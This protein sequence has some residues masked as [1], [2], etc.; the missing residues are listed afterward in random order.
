MLKFTRSLLNS[1]LGRKRTIENDDDTSNHDQ[2]SK[3]LKTDENQKS[4]YRVTVSNLPVY[5]IG[6]IKKLLN[7]AGL[8][9]IKKAPEWTY[10]HCFAD[11]KEEAE[12]A[13]NQ[14]QN[15]QYKG[16]ALDIKWEA[17]S[18]QEH[19]QAKVTG[20]KKNKQKAKMWEDLG[21]DLDPHERLAYQVTPLFKL[22]YD[23]QL[24]K[25]RKVGVNHI[26]NLKKQLLKLP[27]SEE[28]KKQISWITKSGL[29]ME[30]VDIIASPEINGYRTKC[31]FTI[32]SDLDGRPTV[33][34]LLGR[35]AEGITSVLNAEKQIHIPDTAK[36]I[37]SAMQDYIRSS[38]YPIYNRTEK[39]GVWRT[40]MT[41]TQR[42]GD[43]MILVQ[44]S[45]E[46]LSSNEIQAMKDDLVNYWT[47]RVKKQ[48]IHVTT[49]LFQ[50]WDGASNGI[51]DRVPVQT[52]YGDG[53]IYEELLGCRFRLSSSAFFQVNTPAAE[54]LY[55]KCAEWCNLDKKDSKRKKTTLL[56]LCCGTGTIGITMAKNVDKV[57]GVEMVPEAIV[58]AKEN[59][60]RN[61][62]TNVTYYANKVEEKLNVFQRQGD[63]Q[64]IAVLDP[65]RAGVH[66][67]VIR[68]IRDAKH[69]DKVIYISCDAKQATPNFLSLCRPQSNRFTGLP[70]KP[71]RAISVDLFPHSEPCELM[72]EFERV[73]EEE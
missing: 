36:S 41:K 50:E 38:N 29:P 72:I 70:F 68:A 25:K 53:Y 46:S 6:G 60:E 14:L 26:F 48:N 33:G 13:A 11:T 32:G 62:V 16:K 7:D 15:Q 39:E 1:V 61:G 18:P 17:I 2:S 52:L 51:T 71:K 30:Q 57:I 22:P 56:D 54:L 23:E 44:A 20:K 73:T 5:E 67:S 9:R 40:L 69:I 66:A 42:T 19:R 63:E 34:F 65:P 24:E 3:K 10:A 12:A 64:I 58:D 27:L 31:E 28:N 47:E 55:A 8:K 21:P 59:A 35:Y 45:T 43:V 49:L 37:A 4:L